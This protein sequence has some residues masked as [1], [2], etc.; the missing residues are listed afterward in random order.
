[1]KFPRFPSRQLVRAKRKTACGLSP[2][3]GPSIPQPRPDLLACR[4]LWA[5]KGSRRS[6]R[7][8]AGEACTSARTVGREEAARQN[9]PR[10]TLRFGP[11]GPTRR[12]SRTSR[13]RSRHRS[14][15]TSYRSRGPAG[16]L[17]SSPIPR[18]VPLPISIFGRGA[19]HFYPPRVRLEVGPGSRSTRGGCALT[20]V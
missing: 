6:R 20:P 8:A 14:P 18:P 15:F 5:E 9:A 7:K 12:R 16:P 2:Q 3:V 17:P 19:L 10:K 1:M 13:R 11:S 4:T